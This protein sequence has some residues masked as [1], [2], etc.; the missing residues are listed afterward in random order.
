MILMTRLK[1]WL[2]PVSWAMIIFA[3]STG[4]FSAEHTSRII[5]PF[6]QLLLPHAGAATLDHFH[7]LIRKLAHFGEYFVFGLLLIRAIRG[8]RRGWVLRW[9]L[10]VLAIAATYAALDE[11]H[12]S[13]VPNRTASTWDS[14]LDTVGAVASQLT[15]WA[16]WLWRTRSAKP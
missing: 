6:L 14:M 5:L 16:W 13:F 4:S 7:T 15:V 12:Q 11:F 9:S 3:A 8:E 1:Y 10:T 2:P